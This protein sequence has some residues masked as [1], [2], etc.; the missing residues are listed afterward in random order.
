MWMH[1]LLLWHIAKVQIVVMLWEYVQSKCVLVTVVAWFHCIVIVLA[2]IQEERRAQLPRYQRLIPRPGQTAA[3]AASA[4]PSGAPG[5]MMPPQQPGMRHPIHGKN[6]FWRLVTI[7][8]KQIKMTWFIFCNSM[9][10]TVLS[11]HTFQHSILI[12]DYRNLKWKRFT[13]DRD[14]LCPFSNRTFFFFF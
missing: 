13:W 14:V 8:C 7:K 12:I 3:I 11:M 5:G 1:K 10:G 2:L 6:P 9:L 4:P